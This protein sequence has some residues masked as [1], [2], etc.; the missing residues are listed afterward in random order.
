MKKIARRRF[1][2]QM[3][4][5]APVAAIQPFH[6]I[7]DM[8]VSPADK[9]RIA[10][11]GMGIQGHYDTRAALKNPDVELVAVADLYKG[12]LERAKARALSESSALSKSARNVSFC[13]CCCCLFLRLSLSLSLLRSQLLF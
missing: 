2:Q 12:R 9:I 4:A 13:F 3:A 8:T 10:T 5:V 11:I 6:L 7:K 1:I